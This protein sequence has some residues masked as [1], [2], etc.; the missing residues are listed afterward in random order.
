M[1]SKASA[2]KIC[3]IVMAATLFGGPALP[4]N[5]AQSTGQTATQ[6]ADLPVPSIRAIVGALG[7]ARQSQSVTFTRLRQSREQAEFANVTITASDGARTTLAKLLIT[8]AAEPS[9]GGNPIDIA[10]EGYNDPR[11][12]VDKVTLSDVRGSLALAQSVAGLSA[13]PARALRPTPS[14]APSSPTSPIS[15]IGSVRFEGATVRS[16]TGTRSV[17]A[18]IADMT[19]TKL[20]QDT[21]LRSFSDLSLS[22]LTLNDGR[23]ETRLQRFDL[24][25]ASG[26]VQQ[27]MSLGQANAAAPFDLLKISLTRMGLEGLSVNG[28]AGRGQGQSPFKFE[29]RD[30]SLAGLGNG[31]LGSFQM[32]K[33]SGEFGEGAARFK[34]GLA[35]LA[36]GDVNLRYIGAI[37]ESYSAQLAAVRNGGAPSA[38]VASQSQNSPTLKELLTGGPLDGGFGTFQLEELGFS[39]FG[40]DLNWDQLRL[41]QERNGAGIITRSSVPQSNLVISWADAT[42]PV[43]SSI[44]RFA[45]MLGISDVRMR[46]GVDSRFDPLTDRMSIDDYY[47]G[48]D[49]WGQ[50]KF[51]FAFDG[52]AQLYTQ[53]RL[54][55][56][57]QL[58]G[59]GTGPAARNPR[60]ALQAFERVF[61]PLSLVTASM[62][63]TDQGGIDKVAALSLTRR[64]GATP[65]ASAPPAAQAVRDQR[66]AWA[67]KPRETAGDK[68]KPAFERQASLGLA[69][70]LET[71]GAIKFDYT[72]AQPV[73]ISALT[74]SQ[75]TNTIMQGLRVSHEAAPRR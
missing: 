59:S 45:S 63:M 34:A 2:G 70:W 12:S 14:S 60:V 68:T 22:G 5:L 55:D 30:M 19:I 6:Q 57:T 9:R 25:G 61:G 42:E 71:G 8:R 29:L 16:T 39:F 62:N 41:V 26:L 64:P 24:I 73:K 3:A 65:T 49:G 58:V 43:A 15:T 46:F 10:I 36:V 21:Q 20:V 52:F 75:G 7:L 74:Q 66:L 67:V 56:L 53:M 33:L 40:V 17:T 54:S 23:L 32:S 47:V 69:R 11:I 50:V 72:P 28:V 4:Q 38:V 44:N 35:R 1:N 13:V 37:G 27:A 48:V 31:A 18:N 51:R